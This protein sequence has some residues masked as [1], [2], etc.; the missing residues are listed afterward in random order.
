MM[1]TNPPERL[2]E[3][4][5]RETQVIDGMV[6]SSGIP[7]FFGINGKWYD[8]FDEHHQYDEPGPFE[9]DVFLN[10]LF[11]LEYSIL[12]LTPQDNMDKRIYYAAVVKLTPR[13]KSPL[14][15]LPFEP[16][17]MMYSGLRTRKSDAIKCFKK[18]SHSSSKPYPGTNFRYN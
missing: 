4:L 6:D 17:Y 12:E 15:E 11:E 10:T 18:S 9:D 14:E 2:E 3:Q 1:A 16:L 13:T 5:R 8:V 7:M